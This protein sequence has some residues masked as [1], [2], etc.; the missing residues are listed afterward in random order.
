[1]RE[2]E[3]RADRLHQRI[4]EILPWY[5]NRTLPPD[6]AAAVAEHAA[7]C[8]RCRDEIEACRAVAGA[9]IEAGEV[10]PTPHPVRLTRLLHRV[11]Q[12]EQ[13]GGREGMRAALAR[14]RSWA[15]PAAQPLPFML[16]AQLAVLLLIGALLFWPRADPPAAQF[17]TLSAPAGPPAP[18]LALRVVF[19]QA[20]TEQEIR[21]LLLSV[22]GEIT[23]GPSPFGAYTVAV[24]ASGD[25]LVKVL[26]HLR[27]APCVELAEPAV[28]PQREDG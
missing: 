5:V 4:W 28:E 10:S 13:G 27:R 26:E 3:D 24:P 15:A 2:P 8:A 19:D 14:L 11:E 21:Q 20:A 18:Q 17:R 7:V 9:V 22:R 25:P 16:A 23:G 6:E 12:Y 1:M